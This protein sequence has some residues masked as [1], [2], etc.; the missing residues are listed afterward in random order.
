MMSRTIKTLD[1]Q[2]LSGLKGSFRDDGDFI[3]KRGFF[4]S[5]TRIRRD[6]VVSDTSVSTTLGVAGAAAAIAAI[7][8]IEAA[9][10]RR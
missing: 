10:R 6:L 5:E 7:V 4:G 1:G 3:V 9:D 2:E 8:A